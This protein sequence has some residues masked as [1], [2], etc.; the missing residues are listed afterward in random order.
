MCFS[1]R[2]NNGV[3]S[4]ILEY[5]DYWDKWHK[6]WF[7]NC[8]ANPQLL[9]SI[10]DWIIPTDKGGNDNPIWQYF[11]EPYWGNPNSDKL[12]GIFLNINPGGGG[13]SQNIL[14]RD[15]DDSNP[16]N[17]YKKNEHSYSETIKE[18][19]KITDYKTTEWMQ[20]WR[21][22][23]LREVLVNQSINVSNIFCAELIPWHTKKKSD[24]SDYAVKNAI[25]D[26]INNSV[27]IPLSKISNSDSVVKE[28][29]GKI[30]VR[31]SLILDI[32]NSIYS[33]KPNS[34]KIS[35][36]ENYA[37]VDDIDTKS[38][39]QKLLSKFNSYL[40]I[41]KIDETSFYVFSGGSNSALPNPDFKVL[42]VGQNKTNRKTGISLKEFMKS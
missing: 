29:K 19:S 9:D 21:V 20:K 34:I 16:F 10:N 14:L 2:N 32:L 11:P 33:I 38:S 35:D 36:I 17:S 25:P 40:T 42:S 18:L 27:I 15:Q 31:S 37:I 12:F 23:W 6:Q 3:E 13:A 22:N 8:S 41:F 5:Q 7:D 24:I 39:K 1:N 26:L 4:P 30:I 28:M